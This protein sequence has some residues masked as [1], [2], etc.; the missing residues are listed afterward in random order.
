MPSENALAR[1]G[2]DEVG[3][4]VAASD[5]R[6]APSDVHADGGR[7]VATRPAA[8]SRPPSCPVPT[9]ALVLR[10]LMTLSEDSGAGP[11]LRESGL[12]HLAPA[13]PGG[14]SVATLTPPPPRSAFP[15]QVASP[16]GKPPEPWA[17]D[18]RARNF[19]GLVPARTR[20]G[21]DWRRT[22]GPLL[23][24][25]LWLRPAT[26]GPQTALPP[27]T[28]LRGLPP[29]ATVTGR[30]PRKLP[31]ATLHRRARKGGSSK[32][33]KAPDAVAKVECDRESIH[34]RGTDSRRGGGGGWAG[35]SLR[36]DGAGP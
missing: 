32:Q 3:Y 7:E 15:A 30:P 11:Y 31:G 8:R 22:G 28:W 5:A 26:H 14:G 9:P 23:T 25:D 2:D 10:S 27:W 13:F 21:G 36:T 6:R 12:R 33:Y 4:S 17:G 19:P 34:G 35:L 16:A 1:A 18:P 29:K 20:T 24:L